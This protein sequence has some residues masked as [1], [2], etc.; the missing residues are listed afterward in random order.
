[1]CYFI[2]KINTQFSF[3]L[4]KLKMAILEYNDILFQR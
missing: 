1:M 3:V 4:F 2:K